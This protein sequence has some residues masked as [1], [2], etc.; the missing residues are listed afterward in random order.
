MACLTTATIATSPALASALSGDSES[1]ADVRNLLRR[2]ETVL[3]ADGE[4]DDEEAEAAH[5]SSRSDI[6]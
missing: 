1:A 4:D 6:E 2:G 3:T 5:H